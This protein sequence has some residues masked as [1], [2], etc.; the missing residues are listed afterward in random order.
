MPSTRQIFQQTLP[1]LCLTVTLVACGTGPTATPTS[2]SPTR[3]VVTA[4][5]SSTPASAST[6]IATS[7]VSAQSSPTPERTSSPVVGASKDEVL[8]TI[9]AGKEGDGVRYRGVGQEEM[10]RTGPAG[11]TVAPDGTFWILD[12]SAA[13]LLHL[14]PRG[15]RLHTVDLSSQPR[16][17]I[18]VEATTTDVYV[19]DTFPTPPLVLRL[20]PDGDLKE[21]Y[22]LPEEFR[23]ETLLTGIAVTDKGELL[24]EQDG[25]VSVSRLLDDQGKIAPARL[26]GYTYKGRVYSARPAGIQAEDNRTG[27]ITLGERQ[28]EVRTE[29][30]LGG[31]RVLGFAPDGSVYVRLEE[32]TLEGDMAVDQ[33]VRRYNLD[34]E[35]LG[36]ARVP[37]ARQ[38]TYVAQPVVV[39][40]GG[41]VN[42]LL[43][44]EDHVEVQRLA[45]APHLEPVLPTPGPATVG[46]TP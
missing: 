2:P 19:L 26:E 39:G 33:T 40:P 11:F 30:F 35:L 36:M 23:L 5:P 22:P 15:D 1:L 43:T 38:Y 14:G 42:V 8:F 17:L 12:T 29:H 10:Q 41:E 45:L 32:V 44:Q 18:D 3:T 21:T 6:S 46:P 27:R 37:L 13:R 25:G 31:L 4:P 24:I 7:L 34:G 16:S 20:A 28:V 9:S